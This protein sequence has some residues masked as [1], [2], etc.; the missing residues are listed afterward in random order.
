MGCKRHRRSPTRSPWCSLH[1]PVQDPDTEKTFRPSCSPV[2]PSSPS[3]L[4]W[5]GAT[6][7]FSLCFSSCRL[8][9]WR[10]VQTC[11]RGG[12]SKI[13]K[14]DPRSRSPCS[15][16]VPVLEACRFSRTVLFSSARTGTSP[17]RTAKP[18]YICFNSSSRLA[19]NCRSGSCWVSASAFS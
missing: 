17:L 2:L 13:G 11:P 14:A 7:A 6:S 1:L 9:H 3:F 4:V 12:R 8:R 18:N 5:S 16:C 15:F 19:R 10:L